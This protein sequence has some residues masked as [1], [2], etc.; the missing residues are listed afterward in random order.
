MKAGINAWNFILIFDK[1]FTTIE[2]GTLEYIYKTGKKA[3][4]TFG[5][6]WYYDYIK[7]LDPKDIY[8][9]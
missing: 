7:D 5:E 9:D 3:E 6:D 2:N 1:D 8:E 4:A